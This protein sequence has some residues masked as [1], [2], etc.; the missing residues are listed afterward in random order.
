MMDDG[1]KSSDHVAKLK[2]RAKDKKEEKG[3]K[4]KQKTSA[5]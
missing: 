4:K 1:S 5:D 2:K 3:A